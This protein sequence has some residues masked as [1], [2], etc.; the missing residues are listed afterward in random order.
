MT[1][2]KDMLRLNA[3]VD[4]ELGL[5]EQLQV[6]ARLREDGA[7]RAQVER[8][9]A[10]RDAVREAGDYHL[11]PSDLRRRVDAIA[12]ARVPRPR[13]G[14]RWIAW[15]PWAA[16]LAV[17]AVAA[18]AI[19]VTQLAPREDQRIEQDVVAS[20]VRATLGQRTVDV[21]SSDH[22][23]VKPWLSSRLDFSPP[24][25]EL[26]GPGSVLL[27]GRVD[28][29]NGRP[30]AALAYRHAGHLVDDFIWPA[31]AADRPVTMSASRGFNVAHWTRSGM[32]HWLVSDLNPTELAQLARDLSTRN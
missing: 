5:D 3:F 15:R 26:N 6:E 29:V 25:S 9:R 22:H 2:P 16:A 20:H 8:L 10:L 32:A 21:A 4:G 18:V 27:G 31:S 23:T 1:S 13:D 7:L 17:A 19:N 12:A 14:A 11:A 30:V 24:V 28:Y